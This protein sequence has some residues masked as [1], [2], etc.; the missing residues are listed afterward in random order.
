MFCSKVE[1]NTNL[2]QVLIDGLVK[3]FIAVAKDDVVEARFV[4]NEK[5]KDYDRTQ[6]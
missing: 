4:W 2:F 6:K 3:A 5:K 1:R